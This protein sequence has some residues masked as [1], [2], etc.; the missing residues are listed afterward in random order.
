M[1]PGFLGIVDIQVGRTVAKAEQAARVSR[2]VVGLESRLAPANDGVRSCS[3]QQ[4]ADGLMSRARV[5]GAGPHAQVT[6]ARCRVNRVA[7]VCR[8]LYERGGPAVG[9]GI[10]VADE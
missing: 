1:A 7:D 10:S 8:N 3:G 6:A 9:Y 5:G 2:A 4:G